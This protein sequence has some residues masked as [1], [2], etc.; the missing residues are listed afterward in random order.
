MGKILFWLA[1]IF[2]VLFVLRLLN[3]KKNVRRSTDKSAS[4]QGE[5]MVRCAQCGIYLPRSDA[6]QRDGNF[7]CRDAR[8][9]SPN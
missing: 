9:A 6:M 2:A 4:A 8:C 3:S 5:S 7:Y 1:V